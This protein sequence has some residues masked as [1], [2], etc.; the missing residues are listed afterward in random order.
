MTSVMS[1]S[2]GDI[3]KHLMKG[4]CLDGNLGQNTHVVTIGDTYGVLVGGASNPQAIPTNTDISLN[5]ITE[6]II[7]NTSF[8]YTYE[9]GV[10]IFKSA[11]N[12]F[13]NQIEPRL[14]PELLLPHSWSIIYRDLGYE[15][16]E[17]VYLNSIL[18]IPNDPTTWKDTWLEMAIR[19]NLKT[20]NKITFE[21]LYRI[22][23]IDNY[24]HDSNLCNLVN[25]Q[26]NI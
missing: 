12:K 8:E 6:E 7:N 16:D 19:Y 13:T 18:P 4:D 5:R 15:K 25:K 22:K 2:G 20:L 21:E 24:N 11:Q 9:Y 26:L 14:A 1:I 10:V 3:L 23:F 17:F